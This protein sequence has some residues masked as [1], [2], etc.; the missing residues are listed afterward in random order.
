M[1]SNVVVVAISQLLLISNTVAAQKD[2]VPVPTRERSPARAWIVPAGIAASAALDPEIREWTLHTHT[3]SLDHFA[4]L[5]NPLGTAQ[6]LVPVM[7][8][9]YITALLTGRESLATGKIGRAH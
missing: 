8:L 3:R 1:R 5:V 7:A 2:S 9:T 6:R 4:K